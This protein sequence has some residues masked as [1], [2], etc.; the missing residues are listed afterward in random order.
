MAVTTGPDGRFDIGRVIGRTFDVIRH[1]LA[2]FAILALLLAGVPALISTIGL[3][4]LLNRIQSLGGQAGPAVFIQAFGQG[5][6]LT[7]VGA[8]LGVVTNAIL[9]G[10]V[11]FGAAS[12]LTGRSASLGECLGAGLKRCL[13]LIGLML[14]GFV[15][16]GFGFMLFI[17]PGVMMAVAWVAA[18]P[19]LVVERTGVFGAFSRSADLTRG[20]R[21]PIFGLLVLYF[22]AISVVQ[23]VFIS[24]VGVGFAAA[25]PEADFLNKLPVSAV[26]SVCVSI[27]GCAGIASIYYELRSSRE[28]IGPEALAAVFD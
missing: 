28:G 25:T 21:W 9:Q 18:A 3:F 2:T 23:Q 22:V 24:L 14:V 10:A 1:N 12:Y 17:V 15:A 4:G 19:A 26:I 6:V 11:I 20:R 5:A 7:G 13:P 16:I 27:L 8:L